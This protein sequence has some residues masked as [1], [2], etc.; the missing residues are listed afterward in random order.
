MKALIATVAIPLALLA[1]PV[2]VNEPSVSFRLTGT[3]GLVIDGKTTAVTADE[4]ESTV[5]FDAALDTATTGIAVRDKHMK[6]YLE[7]ATYPRASL[8]LARSEVRCADG[9]VRGTLS[10]HGQ[11]HTAVVSYRATPGASGK[12]RVKGT[13]DVDMHEYGIDVPPYLGVH[14]DRNVTVTVDLEVPDELALAK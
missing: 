3:A 13:F 9:T 4:T 8:S 6:K 1:A 10:L 12:C 2:S 11:Q 14:V 7:V 5:V